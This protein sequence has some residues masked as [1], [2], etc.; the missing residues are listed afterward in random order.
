VKQWRWADYRGKVID[1]GAAAMIDVVRAS[2]E[3]VTL[4]AIGPLD[5]VAAALDRAPDIAGKANL[6]G[7]QGSVYRG[8]GGAEKP[9]P[10]FNVKSD[11]AAAKKVLSAGWKSIAITPLDTCGL[12]EVSLDG[13]R[14][15]RVKSSQDPGVRAILES[16]ATWAGKRSA[17]E[18]TGSTI[19]YDT[20]AV[21]LADPQQTLLECRT[22]HI[23]VTDT[24][25][26]AEAATGTPM[27]VA[28]AW[29]DVQAY[30]DHLVEVLCSRSISR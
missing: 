28:T 7:M 3:P 26:T 12:P 1:D 13:E 16:Y 29:K 6:V 9:E 18:L 20:V 15:A 14:F 19:L 23:A 5:T 30:R 27:R 22:I 17:D 25:V 10:E 21:Y 11:V 2:S 24:G 8:Y 4:I